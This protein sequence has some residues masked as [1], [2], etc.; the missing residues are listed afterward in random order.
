MKAKS[1]RYLWIALSLLWISGY[2]SAQETQ[3]ITV[4]VEKAGTLGN[5]I[6]ISKMP[7]ITNLKITGNINRYDLDYLRVMAGG[8]A[9]SG[10][11]VEVKDGNL[12]ILDLSEANVENY[13]L[14][15]NGCVK[16]EQVILPPEV[17]RAN[18]YDCPNLK[19]VN[20]DN[21]IDFSY[22][23]LPLFIIYLKLLKCAII[24]TSTISARHVIKSEV[25]ILILA[26]VVHYIFAF[27]KSL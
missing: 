11:P 4:H 24:L 18:F 1:L 8:Y 20:A 19:S 13:S 9:S 3:Q 26:Y 17:Q 10:W 5:C 23:T 15:I 6:A 16:I 22:N 14:S 2:L 7:L 25:S 27:S 12:K 21:L